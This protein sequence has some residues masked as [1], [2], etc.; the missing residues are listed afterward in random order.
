M[1]VLITGICGQDGSYLAEQLLGAGLPLVGM[2]SPGEPIPPYVE[3]LRASGACELVTCDLAE[4]AEFRQL[5]R[6]IEPQRIYHLAAISRPADCERQPRLSHTVNVSSVETLLDWVKRDQPEARVLLVSS[7][8]IFG[9]TVEVPQNER[10]P[11]APV[12]EYGRQKQA[13]RELAAAARQLGLFVACAIPFNHESPR[14]PAHFVVA[15]ICQAAARIAAGADE[16]LRLGNLDVRRDWGY[17][18]EYA[19][20]LAW[21]LDIEQPAELVLATGQAHS[22]RELAAMA[23]GCVGLD[24]EEYVTS[25]AEFCRD[26]EALELRGDAQ[27]AWTELGWEAVT[28]FSELVNLLV[29]AAQAKLK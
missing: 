4:P 13:V 15:K 14:R 12:D 24:A 6:R 9:A 10:T 3:A 17:A 18:P 19:T 28:P 1:S 2:L 16:V 22:V 23:F 26:N 5:L 25:S 11:V 21:M 20:A 8:A 7:A 29:K 27:L